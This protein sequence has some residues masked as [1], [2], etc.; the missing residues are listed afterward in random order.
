M[1]QI[2]Y[3]A[4]MHLHYPSVIPGLQYLAFGN[5]VSI[6]A[7]LLTGVFA[8]WP[9][10]MSFIALQ[11]ISLAIAAILIYL[12][13]KEV[14]R[15]R[16]IGFLMSLAF[17][18][19]AGVIGIVI[20]NIHL[21][22]FILLFYILSFYLYMKNNIAGFVLSYMAMLTLMESLPFL[23]ATLLAGL[24]YYE[25]VHRRRSP[26]FDDRVHRKRMAAI[27]ICI[28]ITISF[29]L[30]Y[31]YAIGAL[32]SQYASGQYSGMPPDIKIIN[33]IGFQLQALGSNGIDQISSTLLIF[34]MVGTFLV[35]FS[36]GITSLVDPVMFI[37]LESV[38]LF[39]VFV[40]HNFGFASFYY[41]YYSYAIGGS[42]AAAVLGI[43]IF[44]E[45]ERR[46]W[47][48]TGIFRSMNFI[49]GALIP[50][51]MAISAFAVIWLLSSAP[52][53]VISYATHNAGPASDYA[54]ID[55][56]LATIPSNATV[57]TQTNVYPHMVRI[58][59][60]ELSPNV[61]QTVFT[62]RGVAM[63]NLTFYWFKPQYVVLLKNT[64]GYSA[65]VSNSFNVYDYMGSNYSIY[66]NSS[67]GLEIYRLK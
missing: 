1:G 66:Y 29:E 3:A 14:L 59:N 64:Q 34:G 15:S 58:L 24:L 6:F 48:V 40:L 49:R 43:M 57:M 63:I 13:G 7:F 44:M 38:W 8:L 22:G 19:N 23:G 61:K 5:H 37:I 12:I 9:S 41:Q 42:L 51:A 52:S 53:L 55:S 54:Q 60:L 4:Y 45:E 46:S 56:E 33:F 21:E 36:F 39:E 20:F 26:S 27:A 11:D 28:I 65:M 25:F 2:P 50:V 10:P 67:D 62:S 32:L 47:L 31:S 30:F 16:S 35:I 18:F 17:L